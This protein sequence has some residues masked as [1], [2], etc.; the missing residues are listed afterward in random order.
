[1][2]RPAPKPTPPTAEVASCVDSHQEQIWSISNVNNLLVGPYHPSE[3]IWP[4]GLG[5]LA[6]PQFAVVAVDLPDLHTDCRV[7]V[8]DIPPVAVHYRRVGTG[9]VGHFDTAQ[10]RELVM[11]LELHCA[12]DRTEGRQ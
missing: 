7:A 4:A 2:H 6:G 10:E 1:M 9:P 8:A 11:L 12:G 3:R 5:V